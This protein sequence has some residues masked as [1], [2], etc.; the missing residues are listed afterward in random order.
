MSIK[1]APVKGA[2]LIAPDG[3]KPSDALAALSLICHE[4]IIP[5]SFVSTSR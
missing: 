5:T 4:D 2:F 3:N 1:K